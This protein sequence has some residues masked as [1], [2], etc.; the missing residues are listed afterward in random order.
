MKVHPLINS[1]LRE[2]WAIEEG[3]ALAYV[4]LVNNLINGKAADFGLNEKATEPVFA[5]QGGYLVGK[6]TNLAELPENSKAIVPVTG[7]IMKHDQMCGPMG[8]MSMAAFVERLDK[9]ENVSSIVFKIDSPGG[10]V[11]GTQTLVD[12]IKNTKTETIAFINDGMAASAA[13][14]IASACDKIYSS[15]KT[16][17]IGSIGVF[18]S[19]MDVDG[20]L[21][22]NNLKVHHVYAP[23][24]TEKNLVYKEALEGNYKPLQ[25]GRLSLIAQTFI[26]SVKAN[27]PNITTAQHDPFKGATY[28]SEVATEMGLIDG[29]K[30]FDA[31]LEE[32]SNKNQ[33]NMP[34]SKFPKTAKAAGM[35][36]VNHDGEGVYLN[37]EQMEAV[38]TALVATV[39]GVDEDQHNQVAQER[40]DVQA[41]LNERDNALVSALAAAELDENLTG[42]EAISALSARVEEYGSATAAAPTAA[43]K[44]PDSEASENV[45]EPY[46]WEKKMAQIS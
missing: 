17:Q 8:T 28:N 13:Y 1:V 30:S 11:S 45:R 27:R 33:H 2:T 36:S 16:N 37:L 23:E 22:A 20:Y 31:V 46:S 19:L 40:D 5:A 26:S 15:H 10:M 29:I 44:K 9:A 4:P 21:E 41:Q 42:V 32:V 34:E 35:E 3:A 43:P 25:E 18:T 12:A 24:S 38:E 6:Y 7:P 14:W 39:Q